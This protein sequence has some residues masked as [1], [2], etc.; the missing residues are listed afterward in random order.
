[1]TDDKKERKLFNGAPP[2]DID[3]KISEF[4]EELFK[5]DIQYTTDFLKFST[6]EIKDGKTCMVLTHN[7][8]ENLQFLTMMCGILNNQIHIMEK[9]KDKMLA[10]IKAEDDDFTESLIK[11][12]S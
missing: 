11:S 9:I 6:D 5:K 2:K 1:M 12:L 4:V 3:E 7:R 8:I 10:D